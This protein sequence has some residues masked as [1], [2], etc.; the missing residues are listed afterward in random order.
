MRR[1][2]EREVHVRPPESNE[3]EKKKNGCP[4]GSLPPLIDLLIFSCSPRTDSC[5]FAAR[6]P[7]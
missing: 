4:V 7:S 6:H 2:S 1:A 3:R 5:C